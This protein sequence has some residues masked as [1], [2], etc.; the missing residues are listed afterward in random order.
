MTQLST[1]EIGHQMYMI[2]GHRVML[3]HTL[4][5]FYQVET[6]T[7]KRAVKR[8]ITR[9]PN[10]FMFEL[11]EDDVKSLRC[12]IGTSKLSVRNGRGGNRYSSFAFT[13]PGV[14]MLSSVLNSERAIQVN[15]AIMRAFIQLREKTTEAV[16]KMDQIEARLNQQLA[17]MS[18]NLRQV[19]GLINSISAQG[20][21][22]SQLPSLA[23]S[24]MPGDQNSVDCL[25]RKQ[26]GSEIE[27]IQKG[28][29]KYYQVSISDLTSSSRI[30]SVAIP[31]QICMYLARRY[32]G[33]S[34]K[35]I[36]AALGGR[37]HSTVIHACQKIEGD[38]GTNIELRQALNS[39]QSLLEIKGIFP[40]PNPSQDRLP[41]QF[42]I[43]KASVT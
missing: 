18:D 33:F 7:L 30:P 23:S 6:K 15:I 24:F 21:V 4:A 20:P 27:L 32:T 17:D 1:L 36:G 29:A 3:D 12:Q 34:Y 16:N 31:R 10:D 37:D 43:A 38:L 19:M 5:E 25:P 2:R 26:V 28:V 9:F 35:R 22:S 13:E 41:F 14:A 11:N 40:K 8:N 42:G 39:I